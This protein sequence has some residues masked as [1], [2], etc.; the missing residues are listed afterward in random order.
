MDIF[1][2]VASLRGLSMAK[3]NLDKIVKDMQKLYAKDKKAS[4]IISTGDQVKSEYTKND[5]VPAPEG[6]PLQQLFGIAGIPYNKIVQF[7]GSPDTGKSTIGGELMASA[8]KSGHQVILWDSEDKFDANRFEKGFGGI[9]KDVL[10]IK[11]NEILK[12]AE[13]ARKFIIAV[14][15]QDSEAKIL[16]VWDSV[17]GSQSRSHA[18]RELDSEKH[19]QPGQDAKEVGSVMKVITGLFN[20]YPDSIAVYL[21]NQ[22]YA[23]IGFMQHGDQ[24]SG[25][26]KLEFH[27]SGIVFLKRIKKLTK[28]VNKVKVKY[29]I[30]T[31]ATVSKNH[32]TQ[33]KT[34]IDQMDFI[35]T[36]DGC[37]VSDVEIEGEEDV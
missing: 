33:G 15:E 5:V 17:G 14:K 36:A 21:V 6:H 7:A 32:L 2:F 29:G 13:L 26:K 34:S 8:Q 23:K 12:G 18:E 22:V 28:V 4:S 24:A 20:A 19:G 9:P 37:K 30:I 11:T 35:I 10:L 31:R 27:S 3:I 16:F 25:G 1:I